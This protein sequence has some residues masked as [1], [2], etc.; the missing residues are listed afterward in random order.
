V[1]GELVN[2]RVS[3]KP[4]GGGARSTRTYREHQIKVLARKNR[5][6]EEAISLELARAKREEQRQRS[7]VK[8]QSFVQR[9]K[10]FFR[11]RRAA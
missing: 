5:A 1:G 4:H 3:N 2:K 10:D 6:L 11:R 9:V 7:I 8:P